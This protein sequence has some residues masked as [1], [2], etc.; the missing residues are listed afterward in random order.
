MANV[1]LNSLE[2]EIKRRLSDF[3]KKAE[4]LNGLSIK[5]GISEDAQFKD[6][7]K[8]ADVAYNINYGITEKGRPSKKGPRRF[9]T[10]AI[11]KDGRR[12][13]DEVKREIYEYLSGH[14]WT[15]IKTVL[16]EE[17]GSE[18][19]KSIQAAIN[20]LEIEEGDNIK[21]SIEIQK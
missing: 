2:S 12:W 8:I 1:S 19:Q 9:I 11:E 5:V 18:I 6:G 14:K 17:V 3:Q 20:E 16:E 4:V 7:K 21:N 15:N 13:M 10:L